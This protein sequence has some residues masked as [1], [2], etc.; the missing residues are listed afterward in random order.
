MTGR[1]FLKEFKNK[2]QCICGETRAVLFEFAHFNRKTKLRENGK[3]IDMS[4]IKCKKKII[5]EL[6][7]GR[8]M[9]VQCHREE[10]LKE[11]N[12]QVE[13]YT[14]SLV[15]KC[16]QNFKTNAVPCNG[17]I[18]Q[19][20]HLKKNNFGSCKSKCISCV[21]LERIMR[22][23]ERQVFLNNEKLKLQCCA[24][25]RLPCTAQNCH[26]FEWDHIFGKNR[27]VSKLIDSNIKSLTN[28]ILLCR[29]LC[30]KCHR[31]KSILESRDQWSDNPSDF[32][33]LL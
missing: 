8:Y 22:R 23:K 18:C 5:T 24:Y 7:K 26:V 33:I 28:E 16:T 9:C 13:N 3:R 15:L 25:C 10:T 1:S 14:Q 32:G 6:K 30:L 11:N 29:L 2:S 31:L 17:I 12:R 21:S 4:S 20:R 27:K 19:G